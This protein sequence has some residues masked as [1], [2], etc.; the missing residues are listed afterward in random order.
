MAASHDTDRDQQTPASAHKNS[1]QPTD[2]ADEARRLRS[3]RA[4]T[5]PL[6]P[7]PEDEEAEGTDQPA[8]QTPADQEAAPT[9]PFDPS[10]AATRPFHPLLQ[11]P[12][13]PPEAEPEIE[14]EIEAEAEAEIEADIADED[15]P[16]IDDDT[17]I[18]SP[19]RALPQK[20]PDSSQ[21]LASAALR[22]VGRVRQINQDSVMSLILTLP[23]EGMDVPLGLFIVADGMGGH[24]GGEIASR[25]AIRTIVNEIISQLVMPALDEGIIEA[26]QPLMISAVQE[27]NYA[28]WETAQSMGSDMGTT[29]T[30][31]LML[32][33]AL[34][35]AHVGDSRAYLFEAG[36][37]RTLTNDHSTVGRLI[38]LGQLSPEDAREHPLRNQ[39]YRTVGQQPQVQVDFVYQPIKNSTHLL[40]CSDGLWG[41]VEDDEIE[42]VLKAYTW[43]QE[44]CHELIKRANEAGGDDNISAV[45]VSLP[46]V[47]GS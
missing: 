29:C 4:A 37:L 38:E 47:E 45:I 23:R 11:E 46:V 12:E 20:S 36:G 43:P 14:A 15:D 35:I 26:L 21:G 33:Q 10:R 25:L 22:D 44:A 3:S 6:E 31:A 39:L 8:E 18:L 27:A 19:K 16:D 1:D 9:R 2:P 42:S 7:L 32:G 28:I 5:Q 30:A 34:Y 41:M 24:E 17:M 13:I 40:I